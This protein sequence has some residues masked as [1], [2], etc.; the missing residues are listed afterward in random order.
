MV[1]IRLANFSVKGQIVN[2]FSFWGQNTL[3]LYQDS[4]CRQYV[5]KQVAV[6][7]FPLNFVCGY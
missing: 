4:S 1:T 3:P 2:T 6:S 7:V 5:N